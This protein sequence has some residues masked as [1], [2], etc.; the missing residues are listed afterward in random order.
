VMPPGYARLI[1]AGSK[2]VFQMHYTPNGV[3][4]TD[5]TSLALIFAKGPVQR[6]VLTGNALNA[7]F[8]I[9]AGDPSYEVK[10]S[11]TFNEDVHILSFMPH[12]HFRGK[13]FTYT[14]VYPDGRK[15]I[16]L[17]VPKYD[18]N[19]QLNYKL[20]EPIAMPKGSR[21]DCVAHFDNSRANRF[22][23]DPTQTV[24]WGD[25]TWE[26]MMIGWYSYYRDADQITT[27]A[28]VR[29]GGK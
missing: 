13:D 1:K 22:N 25:Q 24:R 23:P 18:F 20:K 28:Q 5:R 15:E 6:S 10:S 17:H 9:P 27:T 29:G 16:L 21:I 2:I 7:Q 14:A 26:E 8:V 3:A 12:M 11:T 19:W 4:T